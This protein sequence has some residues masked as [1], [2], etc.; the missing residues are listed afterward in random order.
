MKFTLT[1]SHEQL[2]IIEQALSDMP[3]KVVAPLVAELINQIKAQ[4]TPQVVPETMPAV[5][6]TE[7]KAA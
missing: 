4:T 1:V 6:Q 3:F 2:R 5:P 7:A